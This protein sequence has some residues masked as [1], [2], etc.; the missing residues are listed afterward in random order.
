MKQKFSL[1]VAG[2]VLLCSQTGPL[3]TGSI[4]VEVA[5]FE[6]LSGVLYV[7]LY[8]SKEGFPDKEDKVFRTA[9]EKVT[10]A[11]ARI[12]F[13]DVPYGTYAISLYHDVNANGKMDMGAFGPLEP[14]GFSNNAKAVFSAPPFSKAAFT[15]DSEQTTTT[16]KLVR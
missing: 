11:S 10:Q 15:H 4:I 9:C 14:Y 3:Q 6:K 13:R 12:V 1:C 16:I 8:N 5:T 2:L 7:A